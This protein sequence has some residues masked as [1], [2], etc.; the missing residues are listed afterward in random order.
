MKS[1]DLLPNCPFG[2]G[3]QPPDRRGDAGLHGCIAKNPTTPEKTPVEDPFSV[4]FG[5]SDADV[6][7]NRWIGRRA[8]TLDQR[9]N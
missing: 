9:Y 7:A 8:Q 3:A 6:M 4:G 2:G 5:G 1:D